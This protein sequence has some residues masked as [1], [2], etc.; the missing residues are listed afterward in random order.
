VYG[1]KWFVFFKILCFYWS[2]LVGEKTEYD[3]HRPNVNE[4]KKGFSG[5]SGVGNRKSGLLPS[6]KITVTDDYGK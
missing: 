5:V 1:E 3:E 4:W 2:S 6:L